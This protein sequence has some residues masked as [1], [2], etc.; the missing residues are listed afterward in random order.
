ML[1][2]K[3]TAVSIFVL[4]FFSSSYSQDVLT[5][6]P[7]NGDSLTYVNWQII[8]DTTATG[9]LLPTRVYELGT[10]SILFCK[11]YFYSA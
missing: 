4:L 10:R 7:F 6:V 8:A 11:P 1:C 3:F 9:G 2:K 5:L